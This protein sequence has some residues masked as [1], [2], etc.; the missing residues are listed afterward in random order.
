M[1]YEEPFLDKEVQRFYI[2]GI[3]RK[4]HNLD[5][6]MS[7]AREPGKQAGACSSHVLMNF[8]VAQGF[9]I[10]SYRKP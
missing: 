4:Q 5:R 2:S 8:T 10:F 9:V 3:K 1:G 7:L 6:T